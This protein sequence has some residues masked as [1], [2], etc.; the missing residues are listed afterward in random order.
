MIAHVASGTGVSNG[1]DAAALTAISTDGLV[2]ILIGVHFS[3]NTSAVTSITNA[4]SAVQLGATLSIGGNG[5]MQLFALR[6]S[7][8]ISGKVYTVN[9]TG[10]P[11]M[12]VVASAYRGIEPTSATSWYGTPNTGNTGAGSSISAAVTTTGRNSL[13]VSTGGHTGSLTITAGTGQTLN[14]ANPSTA[15]FSVASQERQNAITNPIGISVTGSFN[16]SGSGA[17]GIFTIELLAN[18]D[19]SFRETRL[20]PAIFKPGLAR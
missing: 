3:N 16:L 19:A 1:T 11:Q 7:A 15:G 10:N 4:A 17:I 6:E 20:R 2:G 13:I 8:A 5:R 9:T 14:S 12:T 18:S